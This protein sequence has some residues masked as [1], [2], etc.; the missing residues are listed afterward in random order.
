MERANVNRMGRPAHGRR[1]V[2]VSIA[3]PRETV[4]WMQEN[5]DNVSAW[6]RGLVEA[7]RALE[8]GTTAQ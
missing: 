5:L 4:E 3:L 8:P 2:Q 1:M 7:Q 6:V